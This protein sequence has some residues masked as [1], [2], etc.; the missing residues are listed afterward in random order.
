MVSTNTLT[1]AVMVGG[2]ISQYHLD[3]LINRYF[4]GI[5][6]FDNVQPPPP[7]TRVTQS[8]KNTKMHL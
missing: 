2:Y 6:I 8:N 7:Y 5:D 3:T 1:L 4:I